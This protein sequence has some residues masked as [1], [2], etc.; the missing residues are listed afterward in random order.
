[1]A[2][3]RFCSAVLFA[4]ACN[5]ALS[6]TDSQ[7]RL[8]AANLRVN[9]LK[10]HVYVD[11]A[12]HLSW[13]VAV[14]PGAA[15][16]TPHQRQIAYLIDA[17]DSTTGA[18]LWSSGIVNSST[19]F[20]VPYTGLRTVRQRVSW[21]VTVWDGAGRMCGAQETASFEYA[22]LRE[23]DWNGAEWLASPTSVPVHP[24]NECAFY[25]ADPVPVFE[26]SFEATKTVAT[27]RI[28]TVGLGYYTLSLDGARLSTS[29]EGVSKQSYLDPPL[30]SYDKRVYYNVYNVTAQLAKQPPHTVS[31]SVGKGWYDLMP[32]RFWGRADLRDSVAT[33]VPMFKMLIDVSYTDGTGLTV[34]SEAGSGQWRM[35]NSTTV[36]NSIY[37]GE[38]VD[39]T[40]STGAIVAPVKVVPSLGAPQVSPI[41]P[42]TRWATLPA[43]VIHEFYPTGAAYEKV[44]VLDSGRNHAGTCHFSVAWNKSAPAGSLAT[45]NVKYGEL[46][47]GNGYV[48]GMTSVA[49]QIKVPNPK[50]PCQPDIAFQRDAMVLRKHSGAGEAETFAWEPSY[51]WHG[52]RYL[53]AHLD[54]KQVDIVNVTCHAM[55]TNVDEA[56]VDLDISDS[57]LRTVLALSKNTFESNLMSVQSDCPHRERFGYSGDALASGESFMARYDMAAFYA[58]RINAFSDAQRTNGGYTETSP[59]VGIHD[60]GLGGDAGPIG[61]AAY[62]PQQ[63]MWLHKYYGNTQILNDSLLS[64][65]EFGKLLEKN[66]SSI[67]NGLGDWMPMEATG[68][69]LTGLNFQYTTYLAISNITCIL[70]LD[71]LCAQ[72]N[73]SA[74]TIREK[75]NAQFLNTTTGA[76]GNIKPGSSWADT[77]SPQQRCAPAEGAV[78]FNA[79]QTGQ[80]LALYNNIAPQNL[81]QRVL[82]VLVANIVSASYVKGQGEGPVKGGPGPHM[83]SGMFGVKW[84]L[85][86]L[87]DANHSD[88]A[89]TVVT[90]ES[91]P[92]F[93]WMTK[94]EYVN[95]T[96]I[97]ESWFVSNNTY[98]HNHPMFGSHDTWFLHHVLGIMPHPSAVG[99][100]TALIRPR[101]PLSMARRSPD[102]TASVSG[103]YKT[104]RGPVSMSWSVSATTRVMNVTFT[105]PPN[106][107]ALCELPNLPP[108]LVGAGEHRYTT[109]V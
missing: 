82:D 78:Q 41:P 87:S 33:G 103:V 12:V 66:P 24:K 45:I 17:E 90:Q 89:Y 31:I 29:P 38:V 21:S 73:A 85:G 104:V 30:A 97:W 47:H 63:V 92:S 32:L 2:G 28:Y 10:G 98:S 16:S 49:G 58:N 74:A 40:V 71:T 99:F 107:E 77:G 88:L 35:R 81:R 36:L 65:L 51:S 86:S 3:M 101:P 83:L 8:A 108:H 52:M 1:M 18:A 72:Y 39:Q 100:S 25:A 4:A 22:L 80:G 34:V 91:F 70:G 57:R 26:R 15:A 7:C 96:T 43:K 95:A 54:S 19:T 69:D 61:W 46:L 13:E 109:H 84:V 42:I 62:P 67:E 11:A 44:L 59:Y 102:G 23:Q 37:L 64:V 48:N 56:L 94:N 79:T 75:I 27:A 6:D 60:G 14:L 76:Y 68:T 50:A 106:M 20:G 53:E 5:G 105:I 9:Y 55:A 93:Y